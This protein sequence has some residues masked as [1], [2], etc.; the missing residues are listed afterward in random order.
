VRF[1][2][3]ANAARLP[4]ARVLGRG[5]AEQHPQARLTVCVTG[6]E[7]LAAGDEPFEVMRPRELS[8]SGW[9][10][11]LRCQRWADLTEFLKPHL[12]GH[13]LAREGADVAVFLDATVDLH[14]PLDSVTRA[15]EHHGAVVVPRLLGELPVDGHRPDAADRRRVGHLDGS[16]VALAREPFGPQLV[17]WWAERLQGAAAM[18]PAGWMGDPDHAG[19]ELGRWFDL[20]PG[21]FGDVAVVADPGSA[22]SY[23]NLHERRL[24]LGD[25]A[26]TVDG[27]PLRFLHFEGFDP[28]K[29]F[30]LN[31]RADRVRTSESAPL[32]MLCES[33]AKRLLEAGWRDSRRRADVGR[34]LPN[35][36]TFDDRLSHLLGEL[37]D[38]GEELGDV[39]SPQ[40]CESFMRWLEGPA[41][42]GSA[43]GV[44]RYLYRVY[45]ERDDLHLA[46]PNLDGADGPEFAGWSWV[47]G[48]AEMAIPERFLPPRPVG[49]EGLTPARSRAPARAAAPLPRGRKP[50]ISMNVTGLLTGTLGLGEA[51]RGYVRALQAA[52][53][54]AS[55]STVDVREFVE[56]TG[57]AHEG[58]ARVDFTDL[59]SN[60]RA[61]FNLICINADELP[62]FAESV[63]E[64]F[65]VDRPS[66]GVWA[67]E[68]DR[69]PERWER[70][71]DYLDEIWVYSSYVAQNLGRVAPIAV[72][73]IPPPVSPPDPGDVRLELD[74]PTGYRFLFM[75]DFFSTIQRKNPVGLIEAFRSAFEPGEGPQLVIK[76]INGVHRHEALEE[77]LW[78]ARGRPDVHVVDRSLSARERDALVASCDCYVSLHR[79]EGFGLTLAEC[80]VLGKP[81]IGTAFSGPTDFMSAENSYL[82]PHGTT[83]VGADCEVYPPEG[84]WADPHVETAAALMRRVVENGDEA[85]A[86][87]ERARRDIERLYS[88][89]AVGELIRARL[90][91]LVALWS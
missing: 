22:V 2:T 53:I 70:S 37:A 28:A 72:R 80:M 52:A 77:V 68:T 91:E 71:F 39:F 11:L 24:E 15:L 48:L 54:D 47:F 50:D 29:P 32:A 85:R 10:K 14:A 69:I 63:G 33:Y 19:R 58:Y 34:E 45:L 81:V 78:A 9:D 4:H 41:C 61:G 60:E 86:K 82:V 84:T 90:E 51:A 5:L 30:L 64:S 3:I 27:R 76:T 74:L 65:F 56:L 23:W 31:P 16:L 21:V 18:L 26:T 83:R 42:Y 38:A 8:V 89:K 59:T 44:N 17:R 66:I 62:L 87:G 55:T 20:V 13:L 46:Y 79:S 36:M 40:G 6:P 49:I 35:G 12:L 73:C 1:C 43:F 7:H 57:T 25:D 88:P 75:F 67:W